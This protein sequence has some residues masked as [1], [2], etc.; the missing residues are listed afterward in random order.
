VRAPPFNYRFEAIG[1]IITVVCSI[2]D[3]PARSD[4]CATENE[5]KECLYESGG[6]VTGDGFAGPFGTGALLSVSE[7]LRENLRRRL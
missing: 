3:E 4:E 5:K 1:A 7:G 2:E 6:L